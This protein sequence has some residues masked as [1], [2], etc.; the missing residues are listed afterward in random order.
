MPVINFNFNDLVG[1]LGKDV[2]SSVVLERIPM[3]GADLHEFDA[4]T[5][6]TSIEFFPNRPDL[7][8]VEGVARALRAFMDISPGLRS[9]PTKDS[10]IV[11]RIEDSVSGVRPYAVAAVVRNVTMT[12]QI[13]RSLMELQEKLHLTVG[14]KRVK[15]A[16]GVH[17]LDKVSPPFVYKGAEPD[18]ISFVPLAKEEPMTM[19]EVLEKH[20]KGVAYRSILE[21][22]PLYPVIL[23]KNGD[24]L[25]FPP[26][27][28]GRLTTVTADTKN[29]LVDITGMDYITISGVLN[30]VTTSIAERGGDIETVTIVQGRKRDV[31]PKLEPGLWKI[32]IAAANKWLGLE[33]DAEGM[34]KCLARMGYSAEAKGKKLNVHSSAVR[35]DLI[36]PHD[37]IEDIAIGYGYENFGKVLP[38]TQ[39]V[40]SERPIERAADMVR[41]LMVGYGFWEATTL[42]LTSKEDQFLRMR[43][44]EQEVVEVLNPVSE[45]HTCL[46]LRLT[47]SL[48]A[49]LRKSKHRDLPQRIFEVGDVVDGKRRKNLAVMAIHS[50]AGFTEMKSVV[51]GVMRDLSVK[52]DLEPLESG[53]YIQGRGAS[54]LVNGRCVGSFGEL[55]PEVITAFELGYPVIS[56]EVNLDVLVEGKVGKIF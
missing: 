9:Y 45:D 1:L 39:T 38:K 21:G 10:G 5:G 30:I 17:D 2:P 26:I 33:L 7:Y 44:Q 52:F 18:S 46:R 25:S 15:V 23:D 6:E 56:F 53:M 42:T 48:L 27:I 37:V 29:I 51:E 12:D 20:E 47:P 31:T 11:M 24:V 32:D 4:A 49:V 3:I 50:K 22:K 55:H 54:V 35:M 16:I 34:A 36:H 43:V 13:I 8:S 41:Q 28:N 14:R 19:R 40:G